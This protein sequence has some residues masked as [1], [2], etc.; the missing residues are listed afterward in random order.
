MQHPPHSDEP[1]GG[2]FSQSPWQLGLN[3]LNLALRVGLPGRRAG[4]TE[5]LNALTGQ[6]LARQARLGACWPN[7]PYGPLPRQQ[8]DV[9]LPPASCPCPPQGWPMVV[10][11]PGGSWQSGHRREHAFVGASLAAQGVVVV[12][13]DYRLHPEVVYPAFLED[14]ALAVVWARRQMPDWQVDPD[15]CF[16][17]G[18]SAG[19]YNAAM[20]AL[21]RRWLVAQ[22]GTTAWLAGWIGLAGPYNFWPV[23]VP[24]LKPVFSGADVGADCQPVAHVHPAAP[25]TWLLTAPNDAWVSPDLNSR[26]L[27][28]RLHAA[29]AAC[30]WLQVPRTGH[31]SLLASL[32]EPLQGWAPVLPRVLRVLRGTGWAEAQTSTVNIGSQPSVSPLWE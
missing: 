3:L 18:H 10:F 17:M 13:A 30:E 19:A 12:V 5:A 14:S 11:F 22:G 6:R 23:T 32:A 7:Q 2:A 29:G 15:R 9:Y 28:R 27:Q 8:A 20:L 16:L 21:D 26:T 1:L 31:I 24:E 4:A 25:P